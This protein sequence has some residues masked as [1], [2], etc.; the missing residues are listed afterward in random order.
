MQRHLTGLWV[1]L[2]LVAAQAGATELVVE[3]QGQAKLRDAEL[4]ITVDGGDETVARSLPLRSGTVEASVT[5]GA[6][7]TCSGPQV[8]CPEVS[9]REGYQVLPVYPATL[10]Q[11]SIDNWRAWP[12]VDSGFLQGVIQES[13]RG[14]LSFT[15]ELVVEDGRFAI[16]LPRAVLDLRFAFPDAAP[17]YVWG[18]DLRSGDAEGLGPFLLEAGASVTGWV[19]NAESELPVTAARVTALPLGDP[20]TGGRLLETWEVETEDNGFFQLRALAP[21]IYRL[22]VAA[23]GML[24]TVLAE[25]EAEPGSETTVGTISL[26][27]PS[28]LEVH[29]TPPVSPGGK[30]WTVVFDPVDA[31]S[32]E[33]GPTVVANTDGVAEVRGL[34]DDEYYVKVQDEAGDDLLLERFDVSARDQLF[35]DVPVM[36]V[37][38]RVLLGGEP[39][40]GTVILQGGR[41]D[42]TELR[43]GGDGV[44]HGWMARPERPWLLATVRWVSGGQ[45]RSRTL[46][47]VP[48]FDDTQMTLDIRLPDGS[49]FGSVVDDLGIARP[50]VAVRA[51]PDRQSDKFSEVR[52]E[53]DRSGRFHFTGLDRGVY[54]L[55]AGGNGSSASEIVTVDLA[56]AFPPSQVRLTLQPTR[57]VE[58]AVF[59]QGRAVAGATVRLDGLRPVPFSLAITTGPDGRFVAQ[60]P[61]VTSRA[62]VTVLSPSHPLWSFCQFIGTE[63]LRL[64]VPTVTP[65]ELRVESRAGSDTDTEAGRVVLVTGTGGAVDFGTFLAWNRAR[66][67]TFDFHRDD[68][69]ETLRMQVPRIMPGE[70]ALVWTGQPRWEVAARACSGA[71]P[72]ARW[73]TAPAGAGGQL[74]LDLTK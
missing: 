39:V 6:V 45:D 67:G 4:L 38:G 64:D 69:E 73:R 13:G 71:W 28:L 40:E 27:Q 63:E 20:A 21:G 66:G 34:R 52:A 70:Y 57:P 9:T 56:D 49:I 61:Q 17:V 24:P 62:V 54:H 50:G 29:L 22:E 30:P 3:P 2:A 74:T 55:Q 31:G 11:G 58:I 14:P 48:E 5:P 23:E 51:T 12:N 36:S 15:E 1:A 7:V 26:R 16:K 10:Q 32:G 65:S 42:R 59:Q 72:E 33:T 43:S 46:E 8:W 35:L 68:G 41:G 18:R 37:E 53:T 60:V 25:V 47:V 44:F 19:E